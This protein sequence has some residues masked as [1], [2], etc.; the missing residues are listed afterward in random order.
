MKR[1]VCGHAQRHPCSGQGKSLAAL[2]P[3]SSAPPRRKSHLQAAGAHVQELWRQG[4]AA[5]CAQGLRRAGAHQFMPCDKLQ[6]SREAC[7]ALQ[8]AMGQ[9]LQS[10][11]AHP[12]ADPSSDVLISC[13]SPDRS[14]GRLRFGASGWM[15]GQR[16]APAA[17]G[18]PGRGRRNQVNSHGHIARSAARGCTSK[19]ATRSRCLKS[20]GG[21]RASA[22]RQRMHRRFMSRF[23][24]P[25]G[26]RPP[27][28]MDQKRREAMARRC[29][30]SSWSASVST[31]RHSMAVSLPLTRP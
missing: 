3:A 28:E 11:S 21:R 1:R 24:T 31:R 17:G 16:C 13:C 6:L 23:S 30:T 14:T 20:G 25:A 29:R 4:A 8:E 19:S 5:R 22:A 2:Y 15:G 9:V 18:P 26:T 7:Q 10:G 12:A 27:T